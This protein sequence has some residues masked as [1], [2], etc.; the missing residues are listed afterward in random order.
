[1]TIPIVR[2]TGGLADTVVDTLPETI[3]SL[4]ASGIVFNEA[5]SS[6]LLEAIK[7]TLIL[8]SFPDTWK[9]MQVNA[10]KK[11]FSWQSSAEQYLAL[12]ENI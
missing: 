11:D 1:G 2:K 7:R 4:T 5:R 10:M 3:A 8:Y 6:A 12:Y 9:K